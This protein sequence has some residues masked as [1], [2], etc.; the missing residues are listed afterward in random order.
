MVRSPKQV[1]KY[2]YVWKG[3]PQF[4]ARVRTCQPFRIIFF[5]GM[6]ENLSQ[7]FTLFKRRLE[8]WKFVMMC[9]LFIV[10]RLSKIFLGLIPHPLG[11]QPRLRIPHPHP[12]S[13]LL[14]RLHILP[15]PS[16]TQNCFASEGAVPGQPENK[17]HSVIASKL[18][19]FI[20]VKSVDN[21]CTGLTL[22]ND[23][24]L[25][26]LLSSTLDNRARILLEEA[27]RCNNPSLWPSAP[28]FSS[29][30]SSSLS[31]SSSS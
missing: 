2:F 20:S 30:S 15:L 10:A 8:Q 21:N 7:K 11:L 14:P 1:Y 13:C 17:E 3:Q 5:F 9:E 27:D 23:I 18:Y 29:S 25:E 22:N 4:H 31:S 12:H 19:C 28:L 26:E 6:H 24:S 16:K